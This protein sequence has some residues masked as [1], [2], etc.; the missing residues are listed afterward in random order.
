M[1]NT[2]YLGVVCIIKFVYSLMSDYIHSLCTQRQHYRLQPLVGLNHN[3]KKKWNKDCLIKQE[4]KIFMWFQSNKWNDAF[5]STPFFSHHIK[6]M[7]NSIFRNSEKTTEKMF[8][9]RYAT[10]YN[11][12]IDQ[13]LNVKCME[14][15]RNN[16][17][18]NCK[19]ELWYRRNLIH[20]T[21]L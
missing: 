14:H 15:G 13:P 5:N 7:Y 20:N 2:F 6:L 21:N 18:F 19:V 11:T 3:S 4:T 1:N 10:F 9:I 8:S 16:G 17:P 12:F